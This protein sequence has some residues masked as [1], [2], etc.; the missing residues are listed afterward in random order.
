MIS[1]FC[2][3][4]D[5]AIFF[6][7]NTIHIATKTAVDIDFGLLLFFLIKGV[8]FN[9]ALKHL[10]FSRGLSLVFLLLLLLISLLNNLYFAL[11]YFIK[12]PFFML[13]LFQHFHLLLLL[14]NNTF[15]FIKFS[16]GRF[17]LLNFDIILAD[18]LL[19][20]WFLLYECIHD[21]ARFSEELAI[22]IWCRSSCFDNGYIHIVGG[23]LNLRV[24]IVI[25]VLTNLDT[26]V[27]NSKLVIITDH[28]CIVAFDAH[29]YSHSDWWSSH[30][31]LLHHRETKI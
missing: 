7:L 27:A 16:F 23:S 14:L 12:L 1:F 3:I 6:L 5:A 17:F 26:S 21:G 18:S 13:G 10:G 4:I 15:D 22:H 25:E 29:L 2:N 9:Q 31:L 28:S 11:S 19:E 8:T 30:C 20:D 24:N